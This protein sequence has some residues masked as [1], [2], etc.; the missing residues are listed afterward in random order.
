MKAIQVRYIS[1][2]DTKPARLKAWTDAGSLIEDVDCNMDDIELQAMLLA[3]A[4][5][6]K[7]GWRS[8]I[9]GF[10]TLQNEDW[11]ATLKESRGPFVNDIIKE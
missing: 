1:A 10:G 6:K 7:M 3:E 8:S 2:T 11:V 4:Y 5:L 9:N